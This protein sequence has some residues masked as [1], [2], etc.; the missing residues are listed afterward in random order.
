MRRFILVFSV[1]FLSVSFLHAEKMPNSFESET[2]DISSAY[3]FFDNLLPPKDEFETTKDYSERI[4]KQIM[5]TTFFSGNPDRYFYVPLEEMEFGYDADKQEGTFRNI[6]I[7]HIPKYQVN[8][9]NIFCLVLK[10]TTH[11]SQS[12]TRGNSLEVQKKSSFGGG[13]FNVIV[14]RNDSGDIIPTSLSKPMDV[15]MAKEVKQNCKAVVRFT[16]VPQ[17]NAE[18][19]I[20]YHA[21]NYKGFYAQSVS[22]IFYNKE[23]KEIYFNIDLTNY[24]NPEKEAKEKKKKE[25]SQKVM[26]FYQDW[27]TPEGNFFGKYIKTQKNIAF[28]EKED[29][30]EVQV[31]L[32]DL[33]P[34]YQ[35]WIKLAQTFKRVKTAL[36]KPRVWDSGSKKKYKATFVKIAPHPADYRKNVLYVYLRLDNGKGQVIPLS[37]LSTRDKKWFENTYNEFLKA[38]E[39]YEKKYSV[40]LLEE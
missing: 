14:F 3:S 34:Q 25:H 12:Q 6:H 28:F 24:R 10:N 22:L 31:K 1:F 23:T 18:K 2:I 5:E 39:H 17:D 8:S 35:D 11:D 38:K 16:I 20:L 32:D 19:L 26:E 40:K 37:R 27:E 36:L 30:T 29:G 7:N 21:G 9:D 4:K 15:A 13:N 33:S